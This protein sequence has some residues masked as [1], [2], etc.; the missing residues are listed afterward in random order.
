MV[1]RKGILSKSAVS[2]S[3]SGGTWANAVST[4]HSSEV[5]PSCIH[6]RSS[7][8]RNAM[9]RLKAISTSTETVSSSHPSRATPSRTQ[10]KLRIASASAGLV[11]SN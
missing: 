7:S 8:A 1:S 3:L 11:C 5:T 2:A 6:A 4:D 9:G 10:A